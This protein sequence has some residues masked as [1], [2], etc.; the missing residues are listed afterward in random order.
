MRRRAVGTCPFTA[1]RGP[2]YLAHERFVATTQIAAESGTTG[3]NPSPGPNGWIR[4]VAEFRM[5]KEIFLS[6]QHDPRAENSARNSQHRSDKC[7]GAA[8]DWR[9]SGRSQDRTC[10]QKGAVSNWLFVPLDWLFLKYS[11][12][13]AQTARLNPSQEFHLRDAELNP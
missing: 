13:V 4:K 12:P 1:S 3:S 2:W 6:S 10:F 7:R 8:D 11:R 9:V 5:I